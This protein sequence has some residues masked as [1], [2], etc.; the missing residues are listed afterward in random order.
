MVALQE[1]DCGMQ[2]SGRADQAARIGELT[3]LHVVHGPTLVRGEERFG[4]AI[5]TR[6]VATVDF[7]L[8]PRVAEHRRH[9]VL[10]ARMQDRT[11][12][13]THLSS[14][15]SARVH[16]IESLAALMARVEGP[17]VLAGDLN[18]SRAGLGA[19]SALGLRGGPARP[20]WPSYL[21]V[22]RLDHVL[23]GP[24]LRV[25]RTRVV[26]SLASDHLCVVAHVGGEA[27][28]YDSGST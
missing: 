4:V 15:A 19:L 9:G 14:R 13:A 12:A 6:D 26:P 2:R 24:G 22:R 16:E 20:S 1:V 17:L 27:G 8:L 3:G 5:A 10:L 11:V 25:E 23:A 21:P 7:E 18:C 28:D